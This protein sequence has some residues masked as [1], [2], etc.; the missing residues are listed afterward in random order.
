[1]PEITK[2]RPVAGSA[3]RASWDRRYAAEIRRLQ[4]KA[5]KRIEAIRAS[6]R[7]RDKDLQIL[8]NTLD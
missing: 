8:I 6:K 2:S 5:K 1:M 4:K 7:I 3:N